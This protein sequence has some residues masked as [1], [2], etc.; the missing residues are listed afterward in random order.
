MVIPVL[1]RPQAFR[2]H[3]AHREP[4]RDDIGWET[5]A[6][7]LRIDIGARPY[8][9][10]E[11]EFPGKG[12]KLFKLGEV[13]LSLLLLVIVPEHVGIDGVETSLL[14]LDETVSPLL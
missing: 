7:E 10:K 2:V 8:D 11:A 6:F 3:T 5:A 9:D 13:E 14:G 4:L 1:R 12:K